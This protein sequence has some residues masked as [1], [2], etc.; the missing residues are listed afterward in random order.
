MQFLYLVAFFIYRFNVIIEMNFFSKESYF[1][2][3]FPI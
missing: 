3:I 1:L 2:S